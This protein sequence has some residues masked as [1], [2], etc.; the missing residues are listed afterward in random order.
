[1]SG[2]SR[3]GFDAPTFTLFIICWKSKK[4]GDAKLNKNGVLFVIFILLLGIAVVPTRQVESGV[5][6]E[7]SSSVNEA[8]MAT[9]ATMK[10]PVSVDVAVIN[11]SYADTNFDS[12]S[13]LYLGTVFNSEWLIGRVWYRF[14]LSHLPLELSVQR[15]TMNVHI[16]SEYSTID[17]P[18]GVYHSTNDTWEL[19]GIT[20]N[21]Q[22]A[23]SSTPSDVIDS[24]AS[25]DMFLPMHWYSWE[26][27]ADVR[28]TLN[29]AD[30]ILTEVLKQTVE[31]GTQ[32]AFMYPSRSVAFPWNA[33]YLEIEYTTPTTSGLTV[34]GI[35]SGTPLE[36]INNPSAEFDWTFNDPDYQDFQKDY[37]VQVWNNTY[38]DDTLLWQKSHESVYTIH[39][40]DSVSGNNHPFG[41]DYEFRMQMKYPSSIIPKSGVID[42]LYFT[43]Y[44]DEDLTAVLENLE[45]SLVMV[46][47][48]AD[49]TADL[50]ANLE[51]R[52]P[53]IVLTRDSYELKLVNH[54]IEID[55][56]DTFFTYENLN[57]IV[58]IRHTGNSGDLIPIDR[59]NSGGPGSSS[60]AWG[61]GAAT[62]STA[63]NT[64]QQTYDLKIGYLTQTVYDEGTIGNAFPFGV[65]VGTPGR[66]QI[67]Y[68]QSYIGRAGYLD[69]MYFPITN[70]GQEVTY[71]NFTISFVETPVLGR[72]DHVDMEANYGGRTP[73][74][75][76]DESLYTVR[77]LG[78][79]LVI[80]FDNSFYY[81]NTNDLLIDFQWDSLVSGYGVLWQTP[82]HT[83]SY[84]AWDLHWN[85]GYRFDNGTAGY[86][87]YLDFVN[88]EDSV[89]LDCGCL[90]L[91][92]NTRYYWR[93]RACDSTGVWGDWTTAN[94]RY[95][96]NT[97]L[98]IIST[99]TV[100]PSPVLVNQE[101]TISV[102]ATHTLGIYAG[103]IEFSGINHS[104]TGVGDTYS[105]AW[106]PVAA[107]MVDYTIYVQSNGNTW[108]SFSDQIN[109]TVS[110][111]TTTTTT[112]TTTTGTG[113]GTVGGDMTMILIIVGAAA[114]VIVIIVIIM[115]KK[116]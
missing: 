64:Y 109:V 33:T 21:N 42:K 105:Y 88:N 22:P 65:T 24:P 92:E 104:M 18:I 71:E 52:T 14:D 83:S 28:S 103:W 106:T 29:A 32:N 110:S 76:L 98:P 26:V 34:D 38:Y 54:L 11:G 48:S 58:Q 73:V 1:M 111:I 91:I 114:V 19:T 15:A 63:T 102:N 96:V 30:M 59:T 39:D 112:T 101:V 56:E 50:E 66:F 49:L 13:Y 107:G 70:I 81:S 87:L 60:Y 74:V 97:E 62:A 36:Y 27:T 113:T 78:N 67:K 44:R 47:G 94:F 108:A 77:N 9:T 89:S 75:V 37:E 100:I 80:D 8:A 57:L 43:S 61:L 7:R 115:K 6:I 17:E 46:S 51:G 31:V 4:N 72:I 84:R 16:E 55:I 35:S 85:S 99:S 5:E 90:T 12:E 40:S 10:I 82:D 20:Y 41:E 69:K 23:F 116:K 45:I 25:P 95:L 2:I 93:V 3:L 86:D 79:V 68:N 53:T